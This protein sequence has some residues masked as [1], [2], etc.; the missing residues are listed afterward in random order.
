GRNADDYFNN[1]QPLISKIVY[2]P[3]P[4]NHEYMP[5]IGDNGANFQ[6]RFKVPSGNNDY[7]TFAIGR[8]RF[9]IISTEIY[10]AMETPRRFWRTKKMIDWLYNVMKHANNNRDKQPWVVVVGHRPLYCTSSKPCRCTNGSTFVRKGFKNFGRYFGITP[11]EDVLYETGVDLVF[12]GHNHHYERTLPVY[13]HQ[14]ALKLQL[15]NSSA[16]DPYFN[17]KASVYIVT[18]AAVC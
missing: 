3:A 17:P 12:S 15:L 8:I 16:S 4:G 18:G 14:F 6:N 1:L 13:N 11:L 2:M 5:I 9:I 10:Y 7:Y